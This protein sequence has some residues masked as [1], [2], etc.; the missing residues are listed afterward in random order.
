MPYACFPANSLPLQLAK[1]TLGPVEFAVEFMESRQ[2]QQFPDGHCFERFPLF[3][4]LDGTFDLPGLV[5]RR[6]QQAQSA[7]R[8]R[9]QLQKTL[10]GFNCLRILSAVAMNLGVT[11][12]QFR[13]V[14]GEG[15]A[16]RHR[17]GRSTE[18]T[19]ANL[20]GRKESVTVRRSRI[21]GQRTAYVRF[22]SRQIGYILGECQLDLDQQ[23]ETSSGAVVR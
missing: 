15:Q 1:E 10:K 2:D 17:Y 14:G 4:K 22:G 5:K 20:D 23:P 8:P 18:F 11:E 3:Q 21:E 6:R 12:Q 7:E 19:C 13:V 9:S 16:N